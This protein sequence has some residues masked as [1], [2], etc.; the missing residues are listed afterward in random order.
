LRLAQLAAQIPLSNPTY[1][2]HQIGL[3]LRLGLRRPPP[4]PGNDT[5]VRLAQRGRSRWFAWL[6]HQRTIQ[7]ATLRPLEIFRH[8]AYRYARRK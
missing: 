1:H 6:L 4:H 8:Q 5:L 7:L 2:S 3:K